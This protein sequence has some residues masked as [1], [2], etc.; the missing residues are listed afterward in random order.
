MAIKTYAE[1]LEEVQAT[2]SRIEQTGQAYGINNRSLTRADL[3][4]LYE[5]EQWLRTRAAREANGGRIN[6]QA[7]VP[8]G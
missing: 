3:K 2:I 7:V 5:R 8:R 6:T 1:Q 4:T